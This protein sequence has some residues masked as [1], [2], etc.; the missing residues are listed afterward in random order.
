MVSG[1]GPEIAGRCN[2]FHEAWNGLRGAPCHAA[3]TPCRKN[4]TSLPRV[5]ELRDSSPAAAR[6]SAAAEPAWVAACCTSLML[7]VTSP[8]PRAASLTLR[9]ISCAAACCCSAAAATPMAIVCTSS[10]V[11]AMSRMAPTA[12]AVAS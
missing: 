3:R 11:A 9:A 8:V 1:I 5:A 12:P 6:T 7:P 4:S 2:P 10:I